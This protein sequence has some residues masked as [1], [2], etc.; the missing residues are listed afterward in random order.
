MKRHPPAKVKRC[1]WCIRTAT[2]KVT[3]SG[4]GGCQN[5]GGAIVCGPRRRVSFYT[6]DQ[7]EDRA[8]AEVRGMPYR[9]FAQIDQ[10]LTLF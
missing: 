10:G 5:I 7:H 4:P 2:V 9:R 8:R 6:C 1:R 3:A